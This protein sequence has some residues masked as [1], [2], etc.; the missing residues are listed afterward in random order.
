MLNDS[1]ERTLAAAQNR[2]THRPNVDY[3]LYAIRPSDSFYS[4]MTSLLYARTALPEGE[5]RQQVSDMLVAERPFNVWA[6]RDFVSPSQIY[7]ARR[8]YLEN[9][10]VVLGTVI[11]NPQYL[12]SR[13]EVSLH[14][15]PIRNRTAEAAYIG[16][17]THQINFILLGMDHMG[18][19]APQPRRKVARGDACI[20]AKKLTFRALYAQFVSKL[21]VLDVLSDPKIG[22]AETR[23][24][25]HAS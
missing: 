25:N 24:G 12:Y 2:L 13:P 8:L 9:G 5:A 6:A 10:R 1:L 14:P 7:K 18:C 19:G 16:E 4:V 3:Y 23:P 20:S 11:S 21:M 22:R 15:M 17:Q